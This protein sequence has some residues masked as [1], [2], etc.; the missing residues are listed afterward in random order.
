MFKFQPSTANFHP[1]SSTVHHQKSSASNNQRNDTND[2]EMKDYVKK[3]TIADVTLNK[4]SI[5]SI[6]SIKYNRL[7]VQLLRLFLAKN[8]IKV[9][10]R[11]RE[12]CIQVIIAERHNYDKKQA[13][14]I[15]KNVSTRPPFATM[16]ETIFRVIHVYFEES[17]RKDVC[18]LGLQL[19]RAKLDSKK[20]NEDIYSKLLAV[21]NNESCCKGFPLEICDEL[22]DHK[23]IECILKYIIHHYRQARNKKN[24]SGQHDS[25]SSYVGNKEWLT[26]FDNLLRDCNDPLL[27]SYCGGE[28]PENCFFSSIEGEKKENHVMKKE[29]RTPTSQLREAVLQEEIKKTTAI[30]NI[31]ASLAGHTKAITEMNAIR[32][33]YVEEMT[34][35]NQ[36]SELTK[37]QNLLYETKKEMIELK[38]KI[39]S[40]NAFDEDYEDNKSLFEFQK[41]TLSTRMGLLQDRVDFY[42]NVLK[43]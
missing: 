34:S 15:P 37:V 8:K 26:T 19:T 30:E 35:S 6:G 16:E 20:K 11:D 41:E 23:Q 32:K 10:K 2:D 29:R 9:K 38:K 22:N 18:E 4:N 36:L 13:L 7:N 27:T 21:Y 12:S 17:I 5:V 3:L 28:L 40:L 25:F 33:G 14:V 31:A 1:T 24:L 43:K 39:R 42:I